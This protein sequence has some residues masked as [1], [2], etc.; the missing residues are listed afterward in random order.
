MTE[1]DKCPECGE[2]HRL[3]LVGCPT[4]TACDHPDEW[5]A[6]LSGDQWCCGRCGLVPVDPPGDAYADG[7]DGVASEAL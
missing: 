5:R 6:P 2:T 1:S 4:L 3:H 7:L